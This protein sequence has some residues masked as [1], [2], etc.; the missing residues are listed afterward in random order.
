M[1]LPLSRRGLF[2]HAGAVLGLGLLASSGRAIAQPGLLAM[3]LDA[4]QTVTMSLNG[5]GSTL[6]VTLPP[7]LPALNF[8]GSRVAK[9]LVG[10]TDFVQLQV[11]NFSAEAA[12]PMFGKVTLRQPERDVSPN[13]ILAL[14]PSGRSLIETWRQSIDVTFER[15][16]DCPGPFRFSTLEPAEWTAELPDFPPMAQRTNPDGSPSGGSR[17]RMTRPIRLFADSN[18]PRAAHTPALPA[19]GGAPGEDERVRRSD[20]RAERDNAG[21]CRC[22]LGSALPSSDLPPGTEFARIESLHFNQGQL[23]G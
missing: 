3:P 2:G 12:H 4:G 11:L 5:F 17:Y 9:V 22:A 1:T 13:S 21:T 7:P 18:T 19:S 23:I 20:H 8:L 6:V 15:C 16:G 10:G 14:S